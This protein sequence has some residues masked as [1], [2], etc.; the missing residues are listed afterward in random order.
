LADRVNGEGN[1]GNAYSLQGKYILLTADIALPAYGPEPDWKPIGN[2]SSPDRVFSGSLDGGGYTVSGLYKHVG[3]GDYFGLFGYISGG[4]VSNLNVAGTIDHT[5]GQKYCGGVAGYIDGGSITGCGYAGSLRK[6]VGSTGDVCAGGIAGGAYNAAITGC[7]VSGTINLDS[8]AGSPVSAGGIAGWGERVTITSSYN[9]AAIYYNNFQGASCQSRIGGIIGD[10]SRAGVITG[11]RN[12]GALE[13]AEAYGETSMGGIVGHVSDSCTTISCYNTAPVTATQRPGG[14]NSSY[15]G[16]IIGRAYS[17]DIADVYNRGAVTATNGRFYAGG[18]TGYAYSGAIAGYNTGEVTAGS[19][20]SGDC[21]GGIAGYVYYNDIT[22]YNTGGVTASTAGN[23]TVYSGGIAGCL[24]Y[25][26]ITGYNTGGVTCDG[27]NNGRSGGIAGYFGY[28]SI[29]GYNTG[30]VTADGGSNGTV[31]AGGMTGD[32]CAEDITGYNTGAVKTSGGYVCAGGIEGYSSYGYINGSYNAG[33]VE[34]R[35]NGRV[36]AGGVAGYFYNTRI[37]NSYN[38]GNVNVIEDNAGADVSVGGLAGEGGYAGITNGYNTGAVK[39]SGGGRVYA[40]GLAGRYNY[41]VTITNGYNTGAVTA[42]GTAGAEVYAGGLTGYTSSYDLTGGYNTGAIMA[43]FGARVYAGGL[44][45]YGAYGSRISYAYN[46]GTVA[47][48]GGD[49]YAGAIAGYLDDDIGN[50]LAFCY[51]NADSF[52]GGAVGNKPGALAAAG[53]AAATMTADDAL[54]TGAMSALSGAG[55]SKRQGADGIIYYP[56]LTQF[57]DSANP[58]YKDASR[59]SAATGASGVAVCVISYDFQG[60]RADE[61]FAPVGLGC[62]F[63]LAVPKRTGYSFSGWYDAPEGAV[64]YADE[65]GAGFSWSITATVTAYARWEAERYDVRYNTGIADA[66]F[67]TES[68]TAE[69]DTPLWQPP[70]REGY[71]FLGWYGNPE[72]EGGAIEYI[73]EG[74]AGERTFYAKWEIFRYTITYAGV[75]NAANGNPVE[76]TAE[77]E[78]RL[79]PPVRAGYAFFGWYDNPDFEGDAIEYIAEGSAGDRT[80]CAKWEII[81]Y[82]IT[83]AG[84]RDAEGYNPTVYTADEEIRLAPATRGGYAF[85][86]WYDNFDFEG[87]AIEYIAEGSIGDRTLYAKWSAAADIVG[88]GENIVSDAAGGGTDWLLLLFVI[89]DLLLLLV[90]IMIYRMKKEKRTAAA[91]IDAPRAAIA[92]PVQAQAALPAAQAALPAAREAEQATFAA[93]AS[94]PQGAPP[95]IQAGG[96]GAGFFAPQGASPTAQ[97]AFAAPAPAAAPGTWPGTERAGNI[98]VNLYGAGGAPQGAY[99]L[100]A[101]NGYVQ[102]NQNDHNAYGQGNQNAQNGYVQYNQNDHN[103]YVQYNQNGSHGAYCRYGAGIPYD[104]YD[105]RSPRNPRGQSGRR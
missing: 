51:Y 91:W 9:G 6:I 1:Y 35:S 74:S 96:C 76:Y 12:E 36:F 87:D 78:I 11:C 43:S 97:A 67:V 103:G 30:G 28:G 85:L 33:H 24:N 72:L 16:G 101:Q 92:P 23:S 70:A 77:S 57:K 61:R 48:S 56:E 81:K 45:G 66:A 26:S 47:A 14:W 38:A 93:Q 95:V 22:G 19:D 18:I 55:F 54:T 5:G 89:L 29:T 60:G 31:Y 27:S 79:A 20:N 80:L 58:V 3:T 44:T 98:T 2:Y 68:Y 62:D 49:N 13:A 15:V 50:F 104:P 25:G 21:A 69:A 7:S 46:T 63:T 73:A 75:G 102:Y 39:T 100:N 34:V 53:L 82:T 17:G 37:T 105:P 94:A 88:G 52:T 32:A 10:V 8:V 4:A 86:G 42:G 83:Y 71:A 65:T 90:A 99:A 59:L 84:V 40:G 41:S 64:R